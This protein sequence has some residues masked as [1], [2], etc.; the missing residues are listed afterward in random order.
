MTGLTL[1]E[2]SAGLC[3]FNGVVDNRHDGFTGAG[4]IDSANTLGADIVWAVYAERADSLVVELRYA[5]GGTETRTAS[6]SVD[7]SG[8][9]ASMS[10]A[11]TAGWT[12]WRSES[13]YINL[14]QGNN[15]VRLTAGTAAGL[16][17]IDFIYFA[18]DGLKPGECPVAASG[19]LFPAPGA[20]GV[21]PDV[22]LRITFDN[23]P[24]IQSG[25]VQIYD[26][27]TNELVD[28]INVAGDTDTIGYSGQSSARTL[29]VK[30]AVVLDKTISINPHTGKLAYGK[31]YRVVIGNGVFSGS[32][33][34]STYTGASGNQ[35]TFTTKSAGPSGT[36]VTVDDDGPA[37]FSSLQGALNY[38]MRSVAKDTPAQINVRNGIYPELLFLRDKNNLRVMG[39]SR[40]NTII[41]ASNGNQ[42]NSGTRARALWLIQQSDLL[43]LENFTIHNNAPR[44]TEGQAETI[45]YDHSARLIAKNMAFISE[46]DTLLLS[47]YSW[48]YNSLIAGNVDFIWGT[49]KVALFENS[50]IR[51]LGD[52]ASPNSDNGGYVL[53]ARV[54]SASDPGFIFLNSTFTRAAGPAGNSIG[55]GKTYLARTGNG[56]PP[57]YF[58]SFAF[59]NCKMDVHI[60]SAGFRTENGKVQNPSRGTATNGYREYGTTNLSGSPVNL[61]SRV[62]AY[63][64]NANEVN[65]YYSSRS[66]IFSSYNNGQGWNPQP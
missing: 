64:L 25:V 36:T 58:D 34:G 63:I 1:Q 52:S 49:A 16:A 14:R 62:G 5:N 66:R 41:R 24:A 29:K 2:N 23:R 55:N 20:T 60:N 3:S 48:F 44:G 53:Q 32:V 26:N 42:T 54:S 59:I 39:E 11:P 57:Q 56:N 12:D 15:L 51:S 37:D 6:L 8:P 28:S 43:S 10:F 18:A 4:F 33:N 17:N 27:T 9:A 21:N 46:Q 31:T 65:Q 13:A 61:G 22:R 35:W 38:V 40:D 30:P 47:G 50:E 7:N 19:P 45:Y